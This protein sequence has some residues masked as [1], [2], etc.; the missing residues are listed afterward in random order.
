MRKDHGRIFS[1]KLNFLS[2]NEEKF[3]W[4]VQKF[5]AKKP[6]DRTTSWL[7]CNTLGNGAVR[8][9]KS[10]KETFPQR[11]NRLPLRTIVTIFTARKSLVSKAISSRQVSCSFCGWFFF[12]CYP[13]IVSTAG[14]KWGKWNVLIL[15]VSVV[16]SEEFEIMR[17]NKS[18]CHS[19]DLAGS[20]S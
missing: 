19:N 16:T 18:R 17:C 6:S 9:K 15:A 13:Y 20:K 4:E 5:Y 1:W 11:Y 7:N 12:K 8:R 14:K 2:M 3:S 10:E